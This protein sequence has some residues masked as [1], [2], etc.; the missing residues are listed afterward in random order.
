MCTVS[1]LH[2]NIKFN[3]IRIV[4]CSGGMW[5]KLKFRKTFQEKTAKAYYEFAGKIQCIQF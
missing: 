2:E 4:K 1:K 3:I 5:K